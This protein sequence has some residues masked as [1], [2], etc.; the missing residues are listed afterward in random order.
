MP[1]AV[2][3]SDLERAQTQGRL[4]AAKDNPHAFEAAAVGLAVMLLEEDSLGYTRLWMHFKEGAR[5]NVDGHYHLTG[6][7]NRLSERAREL[8]EENKQ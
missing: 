5:S 2:R 6:I 1:T 4:V 7:L 3:T 8:Y